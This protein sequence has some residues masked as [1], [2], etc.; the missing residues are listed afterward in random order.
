[1]FDYG[2]MKNR[3][4]MQCMLI[5]LVVLITAGTL[6]LVR[7]SVQRKGTWVVVSLDGSEMTRYH[8]SEDG[9]YKLKGSGTD[10]NVLVI[11]NG[12]ASIRE[13]NCQNQVC[14][15]SKAISYLGETITCLPHKIQV[16]I[17]GGEMQKYDTFAN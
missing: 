13:A 17:E 16:H 2:K 4:F 3:E 15:H 14:V 11:R 7:F 9:T 8:I 12:V 5:L 1:M 10:Y 6:C